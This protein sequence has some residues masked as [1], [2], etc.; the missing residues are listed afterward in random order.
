VVS[1]SSAR[2]STT[3]WMVPA[4]WQMLDA[5]LIR[6]PSDNGQLP[7]PGQRII[8]QIWADGQWQIHVYDGNNLPTEVANVLT[9]LARPYDKLF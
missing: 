1:N 7:P 8:I 6:L 4:D 3:R 9:L 5:L 2:T